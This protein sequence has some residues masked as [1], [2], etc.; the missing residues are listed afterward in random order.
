M[1][2]KIE[3]KQKNE[4]YHV[5]CQNCGTKEKPLHILPLRNENHVVGLIF[6][7]DDCHDILAKQEFDRKG[8]FNRQA[9]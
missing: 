4:D 1:K 6:S 9:G 7:C 2:T 5:A 8:K 3:Q